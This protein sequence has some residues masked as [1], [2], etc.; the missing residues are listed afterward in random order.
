MVWP[1]NDVRDRVPVSSL[2]TQRLLALCQHG[3]RGPD[4]SR[5]TVSPSHAAPLLTPGR[6]D[7]GGLRTA[8]PR[9]PGSPLT[10]TCPTHCPTK[11]M[12][13][14][15]FSIWTYARRPARQR[16]ALDTRERTRCD[17]RLS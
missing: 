17:E 15:R 5:W 10:R 13:N 6:F 12:R 1:T 3:W 9:V 4:S 16:W 8:L 2:S 11:R 14:R 7:N